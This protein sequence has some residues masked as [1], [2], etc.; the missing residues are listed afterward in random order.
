MG[1]IYLFSKKCWI[2]IWGAGGWGVGRGTGGNISA[3]YLIPY[4]KSNS[5]WIR[6]K[7]TK[8]KKKYF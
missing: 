1:K 4:T 7:S 3:F 8:K 6:P 5:K 2:P